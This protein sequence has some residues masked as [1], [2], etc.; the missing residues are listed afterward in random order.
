MDPWMEEE[1]A[2]TARHEVDAEMAELA[3]AGDALWA[4]RRAGRCVH[5]ST[6]G[7]LSSPVYPEQ[8]GLRPG[9]LRC[10]DPAPGGAADGGRGCGAVFDG[11]DAWYAAMDAAVG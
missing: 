8:R 7:Y 3:A 9:Q 5:A 1:A 11:D 6:V 2:Q 4:A 10:T